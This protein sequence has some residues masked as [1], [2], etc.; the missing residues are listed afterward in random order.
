MEHW[1]DELTA[2]HEAFRDVS[3][4]DT[5]SLDRRPD[6]SLELHYN[7]S[8]AYRSDTPGLATLYLGIWL[9]EDGLSEGLRSALLK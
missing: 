5:Y 3:A 9:D 8:L 7:D 4:G 6:G 1:Q 2:L